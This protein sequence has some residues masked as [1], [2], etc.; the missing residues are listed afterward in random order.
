MDDIFVDLK[1]AG[2]PTPSSREG[3]KELAATLGIG[4]QYL[5]RIMNGSKPYGGKL[6]DGL[7][8]MIAAKG[9]PAPL[10]PPNKTEPVREQFEVD[11]PADIIDRIR[12]VPETK[13]LLDQ[14]VRKSTSL[15]AQL[16]K[17]LFTGYRVEPDAAGGF[18][19]VHVA[20]LTA[21]Y[22]IAVAVCEMLNGEKG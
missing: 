7:N 12:S 6:R 3:R 9:N 11:L 13:G 18:K 4:H 10:S 17:G 5:N 2:L 22:A 8:A 15:E 19:V 1:A 20:A 21:E 16:A 14:H